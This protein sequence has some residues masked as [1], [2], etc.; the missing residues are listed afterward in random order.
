[1]LLRIVSALRSGGGTGAPTVTRQDVLDVLASLSSWIEETI[2]DERVRDALVAALRVARSA[3]RTGSSGHLLGLTVDPVA[4]VGEVA[5]EL[6]SLRA[7]DWEIYPRAN[8]AIGYLEDVSAGGA[9]PVGY[10]ELGVGIRFLVRPTDGLDLLFGAH[11]AASGLLLSI[12]DSTGAGRDVVLVGGGVSLN[13]FR[14]VE[15]AVTPG[16]LL[17]AGADSAN[18]RFG[19]LIGAQVPLY[20]YLDALADAASDD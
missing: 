9:I 10:E 4:L 6:G 2:T 3:I 7:G 11:L 12:T 19:L 13:V 17:D 15:L 20:D 14:I 18:P 8:V 5:R 1:L 16:V